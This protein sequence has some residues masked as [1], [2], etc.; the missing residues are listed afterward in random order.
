[1]RANS[2]LPSLVVVVLILAS[3]C[4][5][6]ADATAV[7]APPGPP[8]PAPDPT[9]APSQA[10]LDELLNQVENVRSGPSQAV[11]NGIRERETD[12]P[13]DE[14]SES[15]AAIRSPTVISL[16]FQCTDDVTFAVRGDGSFLRVFPPGHSN[17]FIVLRQQPSN[18]G[19]YYRAR[20]AELRM[21]DDLA[22]LQ[23]GGD[24]YVDCV[25]NPAAAVWQEPPRTR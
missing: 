14:R 10:T 22:T 18:D 12:G 8:A 6:A 16:V 5:P 3:G 25:S 20:G 4:K 17:G 21:K 15:R 13:R 11:V 7:V 23:V 1:M 24:R 2:S 19:L 9:P